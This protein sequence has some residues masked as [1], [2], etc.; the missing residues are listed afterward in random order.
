M[1]EIHEV[2]SIQSSSK[3]GGNLVNRFKLYRIYLNRY[4]QNS[5]HIFHINYVNQNSEYIMKIKL[6]AFRSNE[7]TDLEMFL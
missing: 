6:L 1:L 5:I 4:K 7:Y 3:I 2:C